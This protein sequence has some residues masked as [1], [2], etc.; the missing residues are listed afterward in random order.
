MLAPA[1]SADDGTSAATY[2]RRP[3]TS[4]SRSRNDAQLR[5]LGASIF[6]LRKATTAGS[7][8]AWKARPVHTHAAKSGSGVRGPPRA[9]ASEADD[10]CELYKIPKFT[11]P[12]SSWGSALARRS[13][14]MAA[15]RRPKPC[16]STRTRTSLAKAYQL[17]EGNPLKDMKRLLGKLRSYVQDQGATLEVI[18]FGAT[19]YAADVLED[20]VLADV[21][22]V[23]TVAH[24]MSAVHFFGDIDVICDIGGQDIKVLFMKNG[25]IANFRLS[26]SCSAGN[27]M[28]LQ[29]MADQ[30][31]LPVTAYAETAFGPSSRR[32]SATAARSSSYRSRQLPKEGNKEEFWQVSPG[33]PKNVWQYV[34]DPAPGRSARNT[35]CRVARSL[36]W[37]PSGPGRLHQE[38]VP[39]AEVFVHPHRRSRRHRRHGTSVSSSARAKAVYR[40]RCGDRSRILDQERRRDRLPLLSQRVQANVHRRQ[41]P[42]RL[43]QPLHRRILLREGYGRVERGD[44]RARRRAQEDCQPVP[45]HRRLRVEAGLPSLLRS[46]PHARSGITDRR[47]R[48]SQGALRH[49]PRGDQTPL[50]ALQRG[51][52][53]EAQVGAH[54]HPAGAQHLH[55]SAVVS[56]VLR[57]GRHSE[58]KRRFFRRHDGRDVGRGRQ[59]RIDRPAT[60]S[61]VSQAHIHNLP[62]ITTR[63]RTRSRSTTSSSPSSPT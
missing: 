15:P 38:R 18:G 19:G 33:P 9:R 50:R 13:G 26:N 42:G 37:R 6:G 1:H 63:P 8:R 11:P 31:G 29:S 40:H 27:G 10:F 41:A 51:K 49:P 32:S 58:A 30:F 17:S 25:D 57:V 21:N 36:T 54:R 46:G 59:I 7:S 23:E 2:R 12:S 14:S 48:S 39:R 28:L 45:Q 56:D 34:A 52:L 35:R 24:M 62:F 60:P 44:D 20:T 53:E 22:V 16:S 47:Y 61:K 4:S 55:D 3:S 5:A 43:D